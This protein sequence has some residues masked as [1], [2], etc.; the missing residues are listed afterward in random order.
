MKVDPGLLA[1]YALVVVDTNV[2][3]SAALAPQGV[4]AQLVDWLLAET[5]LV[6]SPTTFAELE[7]RI[8]KPKF[9][10]YLPVERRNRLLREFN[11]AAQWVDIPPAIAE[12]SFSR[13]ADDDAF[14]H[15]AMA[16]KVNRLI[17]GDEDL[18]CLHPLGDLHILSPRTALEE[19]KKSLLHQA[20]NGEL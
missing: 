8:W 16:A 3:L 13:D 2:L 15:V 1:D 20:F 19:L 9:D 10:R 6:F 12:L 11:A 5:R 17:S 14:V 7:S 18:L 4:P